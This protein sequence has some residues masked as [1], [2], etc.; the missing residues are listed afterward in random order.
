MWL[1]HPAV[2]VS[3]SESEGYLRGANGAVGRWSWQS[4][5]P[6]FFDQLRGTHGAP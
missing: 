1:T 2:K 3:Y 6:H 5:R 4:D